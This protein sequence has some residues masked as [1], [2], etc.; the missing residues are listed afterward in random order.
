MPGKNS[1]A[2][3][4]LGF[5]VSLLATLPSVALAWELQGTKTITATTRDRQQI[6]LGTVHFAPQAEDRFSFVV[7]LDHSRFTDFFLSM[8]EFKCLDGKGELFCHVPYP[9][10]QPGTVT[11]KDLA[12]LEH[13]L[14]FMFKLPSEFGAKLWNGLYF[15]FELTGEGLLGKPQAVDLNLIGAPPA[16]PEPPPYPP[17]LRD[18][19]A[20]GTRWIESLS[21]Q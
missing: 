5:A 15:H 8:K 13:S 18:P 16:A 4:A 21:I 12:W 10:P 7:T 19:I 3:R 6:V 20:P 1:R 9:Y 11:S 14:L 17:A 2:M